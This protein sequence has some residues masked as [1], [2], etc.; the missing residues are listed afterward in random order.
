MK[1]SDHEKEKGP[2]HSM[3]VRTGKRSTGEALKW[4]LRDLAVEA[5]GKQCLHDIR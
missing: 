4:A 2:R 3:G 5:G 1:R